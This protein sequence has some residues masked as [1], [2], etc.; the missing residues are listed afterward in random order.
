MNTV[1]EINNVNSSKLKEKLIINPPTQLLW[2]NIDGFSQPVQFFL[3]CL[4]IF[5]FYLFYGYFQEYIFA[6]PGFKP[7]GWYLTLV[8]FF[9]YAAF[10]CFERTVC[11][12]PRSQI[13]MKIYMMLALMTLG[14]IGF[15]NSSLIYLNYPTQVIFKCC[16]LIP[17]MTGGIFIL[18]RKYK[19]IDYAATFFMVLGLIAFTLA[20]SQLS[21]DFNVFGIIMISCA[22]LCDAV[23]GNYQEKVMKEHEVPNAE[24]IF[25]AYL[26]GFLYLFVAM[27][28]S[29]HLFSAFVFCA[30]HSLVYVYILMFCTTGYFG[31]QAILTLV[32]K[33]GAL[34]AVTV[35]TL[36]KAVSIVI[37][38]I[39]YNKPFTIT[40]LWSGLLIVLG[41]YLN[42]IS[43]TH[44]ADLRDIYLVIRRRLF[45]STR[46]KLLESV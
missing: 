31:I 17:V 40:Y 21:P 10:S 1:I 41:I 26:F 5:F 3:C 24:I 15:S 38:F 27:F 42:V 29:N 30:Q 7:H 13:P 44:H 18:K 33:Y 16:K 43:K 8:Q 23:M 14:C 39:L 45:P 11:R 4:A 36:R 25:F 9:C 2:V 35:T 37:S 28:V 19:S 46:R 32:K 34:T 20:N 22:L 6:F 12:I